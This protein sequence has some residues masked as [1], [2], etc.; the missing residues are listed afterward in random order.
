M[1]WIAS[2]C[3]RCIPALA[4]GL[5]ACSGGD[6]PS[7]SALSFAGVTGY[8][9]AN[10]II[11][12]GYSEKELGADSF[13]VRARGSAVT[14]PERLEQIALARA[15][16][17]GVEQ[18]RK[19]FKASAASHSVVCEDGKTLPHGQTLPVKAPVAEIDVVYA[20]VQ[21]DPSYLPAAE[22]FAKLTQELA[23]QTV[24]AGTKSASAA[25]VAAKCGK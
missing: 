13:R 7:V 22:T 19:F 12:T 8:G 6:Q 24:D 9:P 17:I 14:P 25:A 21:P 18:K 5:V 1:R 3:I 16:E 4:L 2:A 23:Q 10:A 20:K 11:Q 15:A